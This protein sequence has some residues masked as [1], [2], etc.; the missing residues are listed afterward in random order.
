M[1]ISFWSSAGEDLEEARGRCV[2]TAFLSA[3]ELVCETEG[4]VQLHVKERFSLQRQRHVID[5][6]YSI[7]KHAFTFYKDA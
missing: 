3:D 6:V 5:D 7:L 2:E 4:K 1:L